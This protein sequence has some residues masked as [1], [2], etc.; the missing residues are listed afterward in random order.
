MVKNN[1]ENGV[2]LSTLV[3]LRPFHTTSG[4]GYLI[5]AQWGV[6]KPVTG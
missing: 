4:V 5:T 1:P 6:V 3:D 2:F